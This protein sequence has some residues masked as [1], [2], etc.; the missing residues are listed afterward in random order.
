MF[1]RAD[2]AAPVLRVVAYRHT[3]LSS[4]V[5]YLKKP[6][7]QAAAGHCAR[8]QQTLG[9]KVISGAPLSG[10]LAL[11]RVPPTR[12][13]FQLQHPLEIGRMLQHLT[14]CSATAC[15]PLLPDLL[16]YRPQH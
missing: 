2:W 8:R 7:N 10:L 3:A 9:Y 15:Q 14:K 12:F 11:G 16:V 6:N 1:D 4:A 13:H 5:T